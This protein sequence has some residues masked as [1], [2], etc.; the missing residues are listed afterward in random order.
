MAFKLKDGKALIDLAHKSIDSVL[1]DKELKVDYASNALR[2]CH[3][4]ICYDC[5]ISS[6]AFI[7]AL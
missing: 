3:N 5:F 2:L 7:R 1:N 4:S 6:Y